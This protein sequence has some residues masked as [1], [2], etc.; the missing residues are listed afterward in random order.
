MQNIFSELSTKGQIVSISRD[1]SKVR[2]SL[3]CS[4][5]LPRQL[6]AV[7]AHAIKGLIG[8]GEQNLGVELEVFLKYDPN[9]ASFWF[10]F[11]PC[12]NT[13]IIIENK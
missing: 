5:L 6:F 3:F 8:G 9:S 4:S 11:Y 13:M 2:V 12:H 10:Y 1:V 7:V